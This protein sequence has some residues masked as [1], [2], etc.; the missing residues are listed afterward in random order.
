MNKK[1]L[2]EW[3]KYIEELQKTVKELS[4]YNK[5]YMESRLILEDWEWENDPINID[6]YKKLF[7]EKL[8]EIKL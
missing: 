5:P 6:H 4:K 1:N 7:I 3:H 2:K 8:N